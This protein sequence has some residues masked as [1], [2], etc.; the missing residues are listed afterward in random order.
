MSTLNT[1]ICSKCG[2]EKPQDQFEP[3][4]NQCRQC[5]NARRKELRQKHPEKHREDAIKRYEEQKKWL[6]SLKTQC[7]ICGETEPVCLDFHHKNPNEKDFTIGKHVSRSKENL[8]MEINKC[9]CL[10]ANCHRK[11]HAGIINLQD[12]L[13]KSS[14]DN[15]QESVTE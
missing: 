15:P 11:V 6:H 13:D 2:Q 12:Y 5:R 8:L 1:K 14:L 3:G 7:L 10:C 4:R 9:V